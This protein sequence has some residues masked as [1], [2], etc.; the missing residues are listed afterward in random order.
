MASGGVAS[1][2]GQIGGSIVGGIGEF[3]GAEA[4][5]TAAGAETGP[6]APLVGLGAAATAFGA[7]GSWE[8]AM[9][10]GAKALDQKKPKSEVL[11]IAKQMAGVG[12]A[13]SAATALVLPGTVTSANEK[14][15]VRQGGELI[16][17][18]ATALSKVLKTAGGG[19]AVGGGG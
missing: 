17:Q 11:R 4:V 14:S 18:T 12:G 13:V 2:L 15:I 7:T 10:A 6:L 5:G 19:A 1:K 3:M 8:S 9:S 16:P